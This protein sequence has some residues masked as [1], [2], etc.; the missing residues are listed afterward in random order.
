VQVI[1]CVEVGKAGS[2]CDLAWTNYQIGWIIII[3]F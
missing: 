1:E 2:A 3:V